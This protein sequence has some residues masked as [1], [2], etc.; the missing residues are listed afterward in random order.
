MKSY[1]K[2][3]A[4]LVL[5][6]ISTLS[7][8]QEL[9]GYYSYLLNRINVNP[10]L[11]GS[12]LNGEGLLSSRTQMAGVDGGP[13]NIMLGLH[14]PFSVNQG[15]GIKV[16]SDT[17]GAFEVSRVDAL[18]AHRFSL[19]DDIELRFGLS[20]GALIRSFN[21]GKID[22]ES[23]LFAA[24]DPTLSDN[25]Y[26]YTRFVAG[27][28]LL[29]N[30]KALELGF[31]APHIIESNE[32]INQYLVGSACYKYDVGSSPWSVSPFVVFQNIPVTKNLLD[33]GVRG[34][35]KEKIQVQTA[36]QTNG[37]FKGA[38]GFNLNGFGV[39]YMY[40]HSTGEIKNLYSSTHELMLSVSIKKAAKN[41]KS[42]KK[43]AKELESIQS[44]VS[45]LNDSET[46]YAPEFIQSEI[47]TI[48]TQLDE[49]QKGNTGASANKV[50][51]TLEEI[52]REINSL[53]EKY[54]LN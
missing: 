20:G 48:M 37:T 44:Y 40:E 15:L 32:A 35:W 21:T 12:N 23:A 7:Y 26:N 28:G 1:K 25:D 46:T 53:I 11:T 30:W 38:V 16:M 51:L 41:F 45:D 22:T 33:V 10:A 8:G 18:F 43:S 52:E 31:S 39:T 34:E 13:R 14:A 42:S 50:A 49:L 5:F 47:K 27:F 9:S 6:F 36:Y 17:R 29:L 2:A 19:N 3:S 54:K 24:D 4:L